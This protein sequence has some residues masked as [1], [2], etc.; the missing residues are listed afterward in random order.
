MKTFWSHRRFRLK[1]KG[2]FHRM[3]KVCDTIISMTEF[4]VQTI[5]ITEFSVHLP[6]VDNSSGIAMFSIGL[7][8]NTARGKPIPGTPLR[9]NLRKECAQRGVYDRASLSTSMQGMLLSISILCSPL[10]QF[11][12][13]QKKPKELTPIMFPTFL[14]ANNTN[15]QTNKPKK[16]PINAYSLWLSF[17]LSLQLLAHM[18]S[19]VEYFNLY[20]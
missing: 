11:S 8:I 5:W 20:A 1:L 18:F 10:D 19:L 12:T 9:L 14:H 2:K 6:C 4:D 13:Q 15:S 7:L 17:L 16:K 3:P